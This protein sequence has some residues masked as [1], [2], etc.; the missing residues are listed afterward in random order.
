MSQN[1]NR[2]IIKMI[3][4]YVSIIRYLKIVA[5]LTSVTE[6]TVTCKLQLQK[7]VLSAGEQAFWQP[8]Y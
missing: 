7:R 2:I 8:Y 4:D 6:F 1:A 5:L 3:T